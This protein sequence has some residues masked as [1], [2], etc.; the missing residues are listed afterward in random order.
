MYNATALVIPYLPALAASSPMFDEQLQEAVDNRMEWI[1]RH[2]AAIPETQGEIL[3]EP[4]ASISDYRRRILQPMYQAIE[5]RPGARVLKRDFLNAR[6]AVLKFARRALEIRVLD[7]QECVKVDVAIAVFVRSVLRYYAQQVT[8]GRMSM[9]PRRILLD[10][11]H[12]TTRCG[13]GARVVAPQFGDQL[14][15]DAAGKA[16][17]RDALRALNRLALRTVRRDEAHYLELVGNIIEAGSL[18]ER[19]R[20]RLAPFSRDTEALHRETRSVYGELSDCLLENVPW[21]GRW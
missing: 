20:D 9:P 19:I 1:F 17:A 3:P 10:D 12:A 14:E 18:S 2:Q 8:A 16:S 21:S 6:G 5:A 4:I 13:S 15:R 11:F 7:M